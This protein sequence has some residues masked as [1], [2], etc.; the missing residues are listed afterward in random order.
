MTAPFYRPSSEDTSQTE[1]LKVRSVV[2][3]RACKALASLVRSEYGDRHSLACIA[4]TWGE[5]ISPVQLAALHELEGPLSIAES[6]EEL[7][8]DLC[9]RPEV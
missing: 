9:E 3:A 1:T 7:V 4:E 2:L 5:G 6:D 8:N